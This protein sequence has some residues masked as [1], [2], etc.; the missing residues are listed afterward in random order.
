M[1]VLAGGR[2]ILYRLPFVWRILKSGFLRAIL[3]LAGA[4]ASSQ[5]IKVIVAPLLTRVYTPDDFGRLALFTAISSLA[6][7][8]SSMEY[9]A[10]IPLPEEDSLARRALVL[11]LLL[12]CL[13]AIVSGVLLF[14][15]ISKFQAVELIRQVTAF[16]WL[17]PC[18]TATLGLYQVLNWWG[19]R[20]KSYGIIARTRIEQG[21]AGSFVQIGGGLAGTGYWG[22]L[23]G[24]IVGE[25]AGIG[26]LSRL[27]RGQVRDIIS[28]T[29]LRD[30]REV[31]ARYRK[32]P[33][34]A[35]PAAF[36]NQFGATLP[37][38]FLTA[39]HGA[40]AVGLYSLT[41]RLT[42]APMSMVGEAISKAFLG[43]AADVVRNEPSR[44]QPLFGMLLAKMICVATFAVAP[45]L[46][47]LSFVMPVVFGS[48]WAEAGLF[49]RIL[50][51]M[52]VMQFVASPFGGTLSILERQE[53]HLFR[54]LM[55]MLLVVL[56]GFFCWKARL[57]QT[58][59]MAAVSIAGTL[60]YVL[61]IGVAKYAVDIHARQIL[62]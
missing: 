39:V 49:L 32:F 15:L 45:F 7:R 50:I 8:I 26:A 36:L 41:Q 51:P 57:S 16:W 61:Y 18:A 38:Y 28:S 30:L 40:E 31:A 6:G 46:L 19:L 53:L 22:L 62:T 48:A 12:V 58:W 4:N 59:T 23:I 10:A 9:D 5:A 24:G 14:V 25:C 20:A 13:T 42:G 44:L 35:M 27:L 47:I 2:K 11:C 17:V 1:R 60:G 21:L 52:N 34:I 33:L 55:R 54:E 56:A 43:E 37:V 29:S 3:Q